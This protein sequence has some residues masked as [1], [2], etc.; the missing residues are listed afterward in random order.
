MVIIIDTVFSRKILSALGP[1]KSV[2]GPRAN[3]KCYWPGSFSDVSVSRKISAYM[4]RIT[5]VLNEF[6]IKVN[7]KNTDFF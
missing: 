3:K 5:R 2:I 1:I 7:I 6:G 4:N